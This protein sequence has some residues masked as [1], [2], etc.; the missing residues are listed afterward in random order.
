MTV[1]KSTKEIFPVPSL[2]TSLII[3]LIS[4]FFGSKPKALIA[5]WNSSKNEWWVKHHQNHKKTKQNWWTL[6]GHVHLQFLDVNVS[7]S[8]GVKQLKGLP[9]FL[10]LL[11]SQL[12]FGGCLLTRRGY[13]ALQ[14]WS[15]ST[16]CLEMKTYLLTRWKRKHSNSHKNERSFGWRCNLFSRRLNLNIYR[17]T[18]D[19]YMKC[20]NRTFV[21]LWLN[22]LLTIAV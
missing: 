4:S 22:I 8:I 6:S 12:W 3:F 17:F 20:N 14:R 7:G 21:I 10:F 9:D 15:F 2:S 11:L 1:R 19:L 5:T 13:R 18:H 16:G